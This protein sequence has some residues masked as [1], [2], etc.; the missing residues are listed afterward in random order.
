MNSKKFRLGAY[1]SVLTLIVTAIAVVINLSLSKVPDSVKT[2]DMS[3][4]NLYTLSSQTEEVLKALDKDV[5]ILI[6]GVEDG[7]DVSF[8]RLIKNY[9]EGSSH[10]KAEYVDPAVNVSMANQYTEL[11]QGSVVVKCGNREVPIDYHEIYVT[12]YSSYYSSGQTSTEF[13]GEGQ[14]TSAIAIVTSE[15]GTKMCEVTGHGEQSMSNTVSAL[16]AKQNIQTEELNL[17]T[18]DI[19]EDCDILLMLAPVRDYTD[20]EA[21]KVKDYLGRG[22]RVI[23]L[24]TYT[25]QSMANF[26]SIVDDYGITINSGIAMETS[27]FYYTY[28]MYIIPSIENSA[29]TESLIQ[30]RANILLP[31]ALALTEHEA[32]GVLLT[33]LLS[34]SGGAYVKQVVDGQI[35][36]VEQ[37][38]GDMTGPFY[39]GIMSEKGEDGSEGSLIVISSSSLIED[40]VSSMTGTNNE[41]FISSLAYLSGGEEAQPFA[42][43]SKSMDVQYITVPSG[44]LSIWMALTV[45]I[46]PL[47]IF[48]TGLVIWIKRRRR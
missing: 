34:S 16:V 8:T 9:E 21:Q 22:G 37:E 17:M 2:A 18:S 29:I 38:P 42:I 36:N 13:D 41:L 10:I 26:N 11:S 45:V 35:L 4:N 5:N 23:T 43:A 48:I 24:L 14:I 30:E 6:L 15:S 7:F 12:D 20:V 40:S 25:D 19:P 44:Q 46:I 3:P 28:P 31:N 47:A 33:E 27:G 39:Y 32:D 1:S